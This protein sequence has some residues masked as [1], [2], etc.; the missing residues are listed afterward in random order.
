MFPIQLSDTGIY[1]LFHDFF[2]IVWVQTLHTANVNII[3]IQNPIVY[4]L[5]FLDY[6]Y[7]VS[8]IEKYLYFYWL[9]SISQT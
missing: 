3:Y 8:K 4:E 6:M 1:W 5:I 9:S 7:Q 2:F